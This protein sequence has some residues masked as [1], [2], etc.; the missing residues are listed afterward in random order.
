MKTNFS[1]AF[2][3]MEI[4]MT[5]KSRIFEVLPY[6]PKELKDKLERL[7]NANCFEVEEIRVRANLPVILEIWGESCFLTR[8]G[9]ITNYENNAYYASSE[10]VKTIFSAICENSVYAY[11][12]EIRQG[13][14][15][16]KGGHRVG[17]CGRA[18]TENGTIRTFREVS[19]L[20]FR[21]ARQIIGVA[22]GVIDS[23]VNNAEIESSL[24]ISPPQ[25]GK[26]TLLR[27]L[28]RQISNRG[29]K[30]AVAD[31]R[32][33]IGAMYDGVIQNDIGAQTDVMDNL[34]KSD[35]ILMMIKTMSPRVIISDEIAD[36]KDVAAIRLA[37]GTGVSVIATTHGDS[38]EDVRNRDVLKPLF[39]D[40]VFKLA[41]LL[42]RDT[43][44]TETVMYTKI[45]KL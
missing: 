43:S 28:T 2:D 22:D 24:I 39:D 30:T 27:D 10:E 13:F 1:L 11:L 36:G 8:T 34:P 3:G 29:F 19:S 26:T 40:R 6:F 42:K 44:G 14:V 5:N 35:A 20:N 45:V 7:A 23:V 38:I 37:H 16:I 31:D 17:I 9:G 15:T 21:I 18:V 32:G 41:I 25:M 33:E 12:D 4:F